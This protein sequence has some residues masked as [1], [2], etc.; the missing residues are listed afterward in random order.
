MII[1]I[2]I[3]LEILLLIAM[4]RFKRTSD[5]LIHI[6]LKLNEELLT[7]LCVRTQGR[8]QAEYRVLRQQVQGMMTKF[9]WENV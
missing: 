5:Q 8:E 3:V 2:F 1:T 7:D 4:D 9:P 6:L